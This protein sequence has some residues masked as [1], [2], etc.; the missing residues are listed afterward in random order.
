MTHPGRPVRVTSISY[1]CRPLEAVADVVDREGARGV[2]LIALPEAWPVQGTPGRS[3]TLDGPTISTMCELAQR[4]R[5][6]IA[7]PLD[8]QDGTRRV[9]SAVLID[10]GG[11]V[12]GVYDK[13]YP[14]WNEFDLTPPVQ[15]GLEAPVF[16]TD[17]GRVGICICFDVNFPEIWSELAARG[18]ELVIWPSAYSGGTTLQAHALMNH[19]YILTSTRD[20]D[21]IVYDITGQQLL[22]ERSNDINVSRITLDL[23]RGIYHENFNMERLERL[24][25][26]RGEDVVLE[27]HLLREQWFVLRARRPGVSARRL[28]HEYGLEEL[29]E[30]VSRSRRQI[31]GMRR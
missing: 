14:Y 7:C 16:E 15:A 21:C 13:I 11:K 25:A 10:R 23:D 3:E 2:D 5:S 22:D 4:H 18:V 28:A 20:V 12:V 19:Y 29:R 6:Y 8:R 31:D 1:S 26:E 24:L 9:N 27:S 17:F 30:Y